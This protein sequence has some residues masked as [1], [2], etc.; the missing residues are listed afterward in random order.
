M[1]LTR[2]IRHG[3][4][5]TSAGVGAMLAGLQLGVAHVPWPIWATWGA[6]SVVAVV[7]AIRSE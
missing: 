1:T 2:I 6:L 3:S 5:I 4:I 7:Q